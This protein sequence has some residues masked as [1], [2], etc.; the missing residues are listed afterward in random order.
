MLLSVQSCYLCAHCPSAAV[1]KFSS[2]MT[3]SMPINGPTLPCLHPFPAPVPTLP[4]LHPFPAP[5]PTTLLPVDS[6]TALNTSE[7]WNC[8]ALVVSG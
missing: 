1:W 2:P 3:N 8:A 5:V 7:Q 4:C 6:L